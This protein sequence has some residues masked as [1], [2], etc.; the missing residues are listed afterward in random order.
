MVSFD[1]AHLSCGDKASMYDVIGMRARVM[2][3][4]C[5]SK[6]VEREETRM[7]ASTILYACLSLQLISIIY[8]E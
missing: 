8:D 4:L 7:A 1:S 3:S 2:K 5:F 6:P